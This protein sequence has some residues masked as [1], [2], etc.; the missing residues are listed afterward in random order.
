M[1]YMK[2]ECPEVMLIIINRSLFV[3]VFLKLEAHIFTRLC[4]Q[5][6]VSLSQI[7]IMWSPWLTQPIRRQCYK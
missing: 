3:S 4:H 7:Q 5:A 2:L 1:Q 6:F